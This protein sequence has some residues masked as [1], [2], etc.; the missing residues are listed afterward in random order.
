[1]TQTQAQWPFREQPRAPA[2]P[3]G[4]GS[5]PYTTGVMV[6]RLALGLWIYLVNSRNIRRAALTK[7]R[8]RSRVRATRALLRPRNTF[9]DMDRVTPSNNPAFFDAL[10]H[11]ENLK[12][13]NNEYFFVLDH[14]GRIWANGG[15]PSIAISENGLR[16]GPSMIQLEQNDAKDPKPIE[17]IIQAALQGGGFVLYDWKHPQTE[18][19]QPKLSYV[20]EVEGTPLILGCGHYM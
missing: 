1:M 11:I 2:A 12:E 4:A 16:P 20:Q 6:V 10:Q 17:R 7:E 8:L 3:A 19:I 9:Q 18:E 13:D 15:Q 14:Q 5:P